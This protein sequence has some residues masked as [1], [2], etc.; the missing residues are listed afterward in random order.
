MDKVYN[1]VVFM[2]IQTTK[3]RQEIHN[4]KRHGLRDWQSPCTLILI[5]ERVGEQQ[6]SIKLI[7]KAGVA[8]GSI[9]FSI[10][11]DSDCCLIIVN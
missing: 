9:Y 11:E 8:C 1:I 10:N 6:A 3:C 2:E 5:Y 4:S 7:S